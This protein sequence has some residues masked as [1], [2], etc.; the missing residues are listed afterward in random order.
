MNQYE[1]CSVQSSKQVI[2]DFNN[3]GRHEIVEGCLIFGYRGGG[4]A[5]NACA[6]DVVY[7]ILGFQDGKIVHVENEFR[8]AYSKI[9]LPILNANLKKSQGDRADKESLGIAMDFLSSPVPK[10]P[11]SKCPVEEFIA[12][13]KRRLPPEKE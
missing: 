9:V 7:H 3:D 8:D 10:G 2:D 11:S 1:D 5:C 12:R 4:Q 6:H 13:P